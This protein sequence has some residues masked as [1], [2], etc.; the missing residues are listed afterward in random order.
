MSRSIQRLP[1]VKAKTG[2]CRSGLYRDITVGLFPKQVHLGARSV[3]WP[4]DE[5]DAVIAARIAGKSDLEIRALVDRLHANRLHLRVIPNV[6]S[7][8]DEVA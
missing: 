6:Q 2:K 4:A 1:I 3:G 8:Q 5:V 7:A